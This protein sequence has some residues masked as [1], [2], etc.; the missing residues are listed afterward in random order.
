MGEGNSVKFV[1]EVLKRFFK[2]H[3]DPPNFDL[4][5]LSVELIA[6]GSVD[7]DGGKVQFEFF[8]ILG[9]ISGMWRTV[10]NLSG[11]ILNSDVVETLRERGKFLVL[12]CE[13]AGLGVL[14]EL[15]ALS[16]GLSNVLEA[17]F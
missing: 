10:G 3:I 14:N 2:F 1:E 7:S 5:P 13:R 17:S 12:D 9:F 15:Y 4:I 8:L 11:A 6:S 16:M